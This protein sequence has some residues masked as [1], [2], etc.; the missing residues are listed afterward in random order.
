[1]LFRCKFQFS[2][3]LLFL[4]ILNKEYFAILG[5]TVVRSLVL[6]VFSFVQSVL[7][8]VQSVFYLTKIIKFQLIDICVSI[9]YT[10][11]LLPDSVSC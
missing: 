6:S 11:V 1:M 3:V 2:T 9:C 4:L 5:I 10:V 7:I 8:F